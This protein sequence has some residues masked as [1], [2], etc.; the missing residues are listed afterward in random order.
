MP[1]RLVFSYSLSFL[2]NHLS[3]INQRPHTA[4]TVG[5]EADVLQAGH[6]VGQS[7]IGGFLMTDNAFVEAPGR[8]TPAPFSRTR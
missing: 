6:Q 8:R 3:P 2:S 4:F 5:D 7:D 1:D